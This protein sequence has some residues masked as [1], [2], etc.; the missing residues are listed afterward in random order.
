MRPASMSNAAMPALLP[1]Y[2]RSEITFE[3]GE[4]AYLFDRAGRR[5]RERFEERVIW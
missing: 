4:G 5:F 3:R 1:V 2:K